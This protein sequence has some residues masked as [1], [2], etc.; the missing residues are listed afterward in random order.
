MTYTIARDGDA[1]LVKI[2]GRLDAESCP[3]LEPAIKAELGSIKDL[4]IDLWG[5]DY[6]SSMGLRLLLSLQKRMFKQGTMH[7]INVSDEVM[8]LF[9]DTGFSEIIDIQ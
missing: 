6:V 5:V 3:V 9:E 1:L 8:E 2:S 7:V 4:T